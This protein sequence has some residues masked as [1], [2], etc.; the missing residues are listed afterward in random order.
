[1]MGASHLKCMQDGSWNG[2]AP[3]CLPATCQGVRNNSAIG[4][5]VAPENSTIAYGRN[6]SI[7]CSQQNRPGRNKFICICFIF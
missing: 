6:V 1:M 4:L 7:V 3:L 2:T 5:F